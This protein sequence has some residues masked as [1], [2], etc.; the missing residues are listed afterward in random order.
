MKWLPC[1][2]DFLKCKHLE[3]LE[4]VLRPTTLTELVADG[5]MTAWLCKR[6]DVGISYANSCMHRV[7]R[8]YFLSQHVMYGIRLDFEVEK[9]LKNN[10]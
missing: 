2:P 9:A 1:R 3:S 7:E 6:S 5:A 8:W 4:S 10:L